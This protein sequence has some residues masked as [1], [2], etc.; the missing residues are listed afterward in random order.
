MTTQKGFRNTLGSLLAL[1]LLSATLVAQ[2]PTAGRHDNQI[3]TAVTH[4]LSTKKQFQAVQSNVED[5]IV[6]LT[7]MVDLYQRKL[8][9]TKLARKTASVQGVRNL[10]TVA[11][12]NIPDEQIEQKLAR[13]L[14]YVRAGYDNTFDYFALGVKDGV[15]TVEGQDRTG[16]GRSEALADIYNQPGVKDVVENITVEPTS[17]FDDGLRLW[18]ARAIYRD[19]VLSKYAIDPAH[20]IRIIVENGHITLYGSVA[21]AMDRQVAGLR[22]NQLFGAFSVENK[23]VVENDSRQSGM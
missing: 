7:G 15:V 16:V 10:I 20:P 21:N 9:A 2:S 22:A 3:Q 13:K 23:L 17:I 1:G 8:D 12:P 19:P 4:K 6:T 14:T 18:A 11:G 5:G